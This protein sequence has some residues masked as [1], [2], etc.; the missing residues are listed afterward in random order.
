M[1]YPEL[2]IPTI[3]VSACLLG[4]PVRYDGGHKR[5]RFITDHLS[6]TLEFMKTMAQKVSRGR[7]CNVLQHIMGY[8][9]K[10]LNGADKQEL[11]DLFQSYRLTQVP[12][13]T[14]VTLLKHHLRIYP[15]SYLVKQHYLKPYP[16]RLALRA[17]I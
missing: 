4:K 9:K 2:A 13:A 11:L 8:F 12:L 10:S 15:D 16:D 7:H 1:S 17:L 6:Q 3:G 14:P 5:D